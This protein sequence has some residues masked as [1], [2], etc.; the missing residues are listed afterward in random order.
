MMSASES[1]END[2]ANHGLAAVPGDFMNR[3]DRFSERHRAL[4]SVEKY[5]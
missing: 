1:F 5:H 2:D 4:A 3:V